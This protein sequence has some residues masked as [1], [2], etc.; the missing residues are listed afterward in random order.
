MCIALRREFRKKRLIDLFA[1]G[2]PVYRTNVS[3]KYVTRKYLLAKLYTS[4]F[5]TVRVE[6][7]ERSRKMNIA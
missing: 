6:G 3:R 7:I 2:P 1:N 4:I 5:R